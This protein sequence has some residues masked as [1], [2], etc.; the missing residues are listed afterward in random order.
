MSVFVHSAGSLEIAR[1]MEDDEGKYEC[2]ATNSHG[3]RISPGE[4]LMVREDIEEALQ[5]IALKTERFRPHFTSVPAAQQVVPPGGQITL[6]CTA[7]GVP[8]PTVAWF[9]HGT[10]L[11]RNMLDR[12]PP[13]TARLS[14]KNLKESRNVSCVATSA[15]GQAAYHV[16]IVVKELPPTPGEPRVLHQLKPGE[17]NL[18]FDRPLSLTTVTDTTAITTAPDIAAFVVQWIESRYFLRDYLNSLSPDIAA[19]IHPIGGS[20]VLFPPHLS[21]AIATTI[22]EAGN[23]VGLQ[24]QLIPIAETEPGEL[25]VK[26]RLTGLKP[27]TNYT[28][29]CR[30][31]GVNGDVSPSTKP[32]HFT[33]DQE[34]LIVISQNLK[35]LTLGLKIPLNLPNIPDN[36]KPSRTLL[37][38][39]EITLTMYRVYY[40]EDPKLPLAEWSVKLVQVDSALSQSDLTGSTSTLTLLTHLRSNATYHIRVSA[41]NVK[42]DGPISPPYPVIVRPGALP[43]PVNF[44]AV[45]KSAHEVSLHWDTPDTPQREPPL[46]NYELL[47]TSLDGEGNMEATSRQVFIEPSLNSYLVN[48][49]LPNTKYEFRLAAVSETGAGIQTETTAKTKEYVPGPP[50]LV[51]VEATGSDRLRVT[52]TPPKESILPSLLV[53][54]GQR[55]NELRIA[56]YDIDIRTTDA[57]GNWLSGPQYGTVDQQ[58][59]IRQQSTSERKI[60]EA[61]GK[62]TY[63]R[64][65]TGL[66]PSTY[67]VV[68]IRAVSRS[69]SGDRAKSTPT[70]TW[71]LPPNR[72]TSLKLRTIVSPTSKRRI[73]QVQWGTPLQEKV[74][75][76]GFKYRVQWRLL[77]QP[78]ITVEYDNANLQPVSLERAKELGI[79]A[80]L[81]RGEENVTKLNWDSPVGKLLGGLSYEVRVA[82]MD[83]YQTGE[84]VIGR[85]ELPDDV[86]T[87]PPS[88]VRIDTTSPNLFLHWK[89]P[90]LEARNG[91]LVAYEV[92]CSWVDASQGFTESWQTRSV[93]INP[94]DSPPPSTL[95]WPPGRISLLNMSTSA[96]TFR[97][98]YRG[99]VRAW[100]PADAGPWSDF[101]SLSLKRLVPKEPT[102]VNAVY[103]EKRGVLVTWAMPEGFIQT[104]YQRENA[105]SKTEAKLLTYRHFEVEHAK[106][107]NIAQ[108]IQW[109]ASKTAGPQTSIVLV[110]LF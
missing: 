66:F 108:P 96:T 8:V 6:T 53:N 7:V 60:E 68:H 1:L 93:K 105:R 10:Q 35:Y 83:E 101:V 26:F 19:A 91:R 37:F 73:L 40:T 42:G 4:N 72:P 33:T 71:P 89:A 9:E 2:T 59:P 99:R 11:F 97:T 65:I 20:S 21:A 79:T 85:I 41:S 109:K 12:Q 23:Q 86:P 90:P 80:E 69:G 94:K 58:R 98:V 64:E 70:M 25:K 54:M 46:V 88:G 56:F 52:W 5:I 87:L 63:T 50:N 32:V 28:V 81:I 107:V 84:S 27:Y 44:K 51:T 48:G 55:A 3:T 43:P 67:Y 62:L 76:G 95:F 110:C 15:M 22:T 47:V 104:S 14:L 24:F 57:K 103:M 38:E 13:G 17:V 78:K 92:E 16:T 18:I 100:T 49:L 61:R 77:I 36:I 34:A 29:W 30:S 82:A 45:S 39:A 74:P 75:M 102:S 106:Q 31:V